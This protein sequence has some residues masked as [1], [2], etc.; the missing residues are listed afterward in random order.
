[1]STVR[2]LSPKINLVEETVNILNGSF[3]GNPGSGSRND[4]SKSIIVFPGKR[5]AHVVRKKLAERIGSSFIPPKLFSIDLFIDFLAGTHLQHRATPISEF[6][7]AA[8]LFE[9]HTSL[10]ENEKIGKEHFSAL[11]TFY[12]VGIKI[13]SELEELM[14]AQISPKRLNESIVSATMASAHALALLYQ[15]FYEELQRRGFST[16]AQK[17]RLAA[18]RISDCDLGVYEQIILAG[19]YALTPAEEVI[20]HHLLAQNNVTVLFQQGEGI[21]RTLD[22]LKLHPEP[23]GNEPETDHRFYES[24]DAHG[25]LFA[26]NTVL[27]ENF[28]GPIIDSEQASIILPSSE[29]LFP[30]YHQTLSIYDQSEYNLALGYPL[31]RTPVYGFLKSLLDVIVSSRGGEVFVPTYVQFLLHPY[32]KNILFATRTDVTRTIVHAIEDDCLDHSARVFLSL[33]D[34]EQDAQL[35]K[36]IAER[37]EREGVTVT[38]DEIHEHIVMI[39]TVLFRSLLKINS[40]GEFASACIGVLNFINEHSTA[41]RHPYFRPFVEALMEHL[42]S[43]QRSL[44]S[45]HSFG[46]PERYLLFFRH[47]IES[48]DVPFTGTPLRG[49]QVLG[50]LETRGLQFEHVFILDLNDDILPGKAQ[51]DVLLPLTVRD[52]LGLSTYRDQER[53]KAY[54]FDVLRRGAKVV[55]CFSVN[56]N[57]KEQSRFIA[58]LQ[59]K[60][61]LQERNLH[62]FN[63]RSQQ[64]RIDLGTQIPASI[65]KTAEVIAALKEMQ[66]SSTALDTYLTCGLKFYYRYAMHL[67]EKDEISGDVEQSDVGKIV[68]RILFEYF[69]PAKDRTLVQ[70]DLDPERMRRVIQENFRS[71]YGAAQFG[72]QFFTKRRV[73]KHLLEFIEQFQRPLA[74]QTP[75]VIEALEERFSAEIEGFHFAGNAD[76]IETRNDTTFILDF[77][78]GH[79]EKNYL[80]DVEHLQ[81]NERASWK[82]SIGSVQ[83]VL[84]VM[85]YSAIRKIEPE[86]IKP[87][88]IFLGKRELDDEIEVSLFE[89]ESQMKEWYPKLKSIILSLAAEIMDG[90]RPFDPTADLKNDCPDCPYRTIC[91]TQWAEKFSVY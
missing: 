69:A 7:A 40:V 77:K 53:I 2:L 33:A 42:A 1:M 23:E 6:D 64:Y 80:I 22:R 18:D 55:H 17:Y 83:L 16:R 73:E 84:Y 79:N 11:E 89:S 31:S 67:K 14:M 25:Q 47:F 86:K 9:L 5:P 51:Q 26:L 24:P 35:H 71:F 54:I 12:P 30:L 59:W 62:P 52:Q 36:K 20:F 34:V 78:S 29:N 19:F 90:A 68:H 66:F 63:T 38:T 75:I 56:N 50:F 58:Q 41:H 46:K 70:A 57:E 13:Y 15:P 72:E 4:F 39:H 74:E 27:E 10:Q 87:A 76:R 65:P 43:L 32:T 3:P 61:Q 60:R 28:P 37:L 82:R 91:G 48:V 88:F 21:Q 45:G 8:I 44:L 85:L 81:V 49:L